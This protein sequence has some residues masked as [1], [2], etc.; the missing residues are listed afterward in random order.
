MTADSTYPSP[1]TSIEDVEAFLRHLY[2]E[3]KMYGFHPDD[4]FEPCDDMAVLEAKAY[5]DRLD[6]AFAVCEAAGIDLYGIGVDILHAEIEKQ[7]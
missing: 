4:G 1:I 6:E 3:R 2:V 7:R 5:A